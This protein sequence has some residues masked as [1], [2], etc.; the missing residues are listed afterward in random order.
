MALYLLL[1]RM[2]E[3]MHS[4]KELTSTEIPL[5]LDYWYTASDEHLIRMGVVPAKMQKREEFEAVLKKQLSLS[6][7]EKPSYCIIWLLNNEAVGHCNVNS[8]TFGEEANMH[9]HLWRSDLRQKGMGVEFIKLSL[10]FFFNNLQLKKL[11][12]EPNAHNVAPNKA[13]V[14]AGFRFV[15]KFIGKPGYFSDDQELNQYELTREEF[16]K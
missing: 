8:I 9:L 7:K 4:V 2:S 6:F 11:F 1:L 10:P 16:V 13:I 12:C 15:K 14:K 5:L 3:Q